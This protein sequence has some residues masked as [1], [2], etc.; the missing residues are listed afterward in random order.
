MSKIDRLSLFTVLQ[1]IL[2]IQWDPTGLGALF[3]ISGEF[4]SYLPSLISMIDSNTDKEEIFDF[5]W[6]IETVAMGLDGDVE[7]TSKVAY[8]ISLLSGSSCEPPVQ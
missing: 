8:S 1:E 7:R 6:H 3:G 4:D 2:E 5:L